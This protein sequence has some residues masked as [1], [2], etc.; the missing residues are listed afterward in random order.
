MNAAGL[1]KSIQGNL[2]TIRKHAE[3]AVQIADNIEAIITGDTDI[4]YC[5]ELAL[6]IV[7]CGEDISGHADDIT[8]ELD[9]LKAA[10]EPMFVVPANRVDI[11]VA[12][13]DAG[14]EFV[15]GD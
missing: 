10:M 9:A 11:Q 5:N 15:L 1:Q 6:S 3:N 12:L 8:C 7:K 2:R 4:G 14:I 13:S